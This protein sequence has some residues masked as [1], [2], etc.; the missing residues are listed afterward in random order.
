M[1]DIVLYLMG[2]IDF[3]LIF[4]VNPR[5]EI[6]VHFMCD[7]DFAMQPNR[8]SVVGIIGWVNDCVIYS[9]SS[10]INTVLT[11]SCETTVFNKAF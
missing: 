3:R 1:K 9:Q 4:R 8:K 2:T 10:T 11:S 7:A 6:K 5:D